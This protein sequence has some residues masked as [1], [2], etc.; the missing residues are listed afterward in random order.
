MLVK[1]KC[2]L[3]LTYENSMR[4]NFANEENESW[5]YMIFIA[6]ECL[7]GIQLMILPRSCSKY[8]LK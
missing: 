8:W 4:Q 1:Y 5:L 3:M 2:N 6:L 7:V